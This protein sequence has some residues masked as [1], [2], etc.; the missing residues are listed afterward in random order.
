MIL[1]IKNDN[2]FHDIDKERHEHQ[3]TKWENQYLW[4]MVDHLMQ[5]SVALAIK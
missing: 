3:I 5:I 4:K 1:E 2:P